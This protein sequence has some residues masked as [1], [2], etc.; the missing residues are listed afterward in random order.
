MRSRT[1]AVALLAVAFVAAACQPSPPAPTASVSVSPPAPDP[2]RKVMIIAEE[3]HGYGQIIGD[4]HAPYLNKLA[5]DYGTATDY[6]AGYPAHCPSLAAYILMTSGSTT[7]ICD[8][9]DPKAHPLLV[10]NVFHQVSASGRQWR[11]YAESSPGTCVRTSKGRYLVRH[12]PATYFLTARPDCARW[13]VPLGGTTAGALHDDVAAGTLP[14]YAFVSPNACDDM[15]GAS[16]CPGD[17]IRAGDRWLE[18]WLPQI[19]AGP[20]YRA[21]RLTV[22]VTWDEGTSG[23][24][25]I[26]TVVVAPTVRHVSTSQRLTHC[27]TLRFTEEQ[28]RLPLL[29]CAPAATSLGAALGI[30]PR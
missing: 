29:G 7:G 22:I 10:D 26:P 2:G 1:A 14:A 24:N 3:N 30:A 4:P 20:D 23:S 5:A 12:V 18:S 11:N 15:H 13:S 21:G 19:M 9:K 8:D 28:L 16:G 6:D 27:S 25:H 17:L